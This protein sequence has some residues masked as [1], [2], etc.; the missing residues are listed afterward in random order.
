MTTRR[1]THEP[2][3]RRTFRLTETDE[4]RLDL[5]A[6]HLTKT[7][8]A[9]DRTAALRFAVEAGIREIQKGGANGQADV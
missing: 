9:G 4:A 2:S 6:K 7:Q 3:T 5:I 1:Y 8:G